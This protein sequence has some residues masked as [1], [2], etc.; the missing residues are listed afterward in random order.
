MFKKLL[1]KHSFLSPNLFHLCKPS[2]FQL[3]NQPRSDKINIFF[4]DEHVLVAEGG[5][6]IPPG[7]SKGNIATYDKTSAYLVR[8]E[9]VECYKS[10]DIVLDYSLLNM[11]N[12]RLSGLFNDDFVGKSTYAPALPFTYDPFYKNHSNGELINTAY[13]RSGGRRSQ[14]TNQ[15]FKMLDNKGVYN[16]YFESLPW[17]MANLD[18]LKILLNVHATDF[19][20]TLEEFRVLPALLRGVVVVSEWVPL[21]HLLPYKDYII[22]ERYDKLAEK[23]LE[24]ANNYESYREKFFG[25]HSKLNET[26]HRMKE[27]AFY[28]LERRVLEKYQ[29]LN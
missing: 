15:I 25:P 20:H 27:T 24:V 28:E 10:V 16:M 11:E 1:T 29:Q 8:I 12:I 3:Q 4:E 6:V 2:K 23:V 21:Y 14:I 7:T 18:N 9:C 19:D 22:F 17:Y 26:I 5:K 13:S